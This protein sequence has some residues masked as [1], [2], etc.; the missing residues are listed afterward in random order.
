MGYSFVKGL[1]A[2]GV[3][4]Q[5]KHYVSLFLCDMFTSKANL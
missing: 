1:Q 4:A 3:S 5:V 2:E